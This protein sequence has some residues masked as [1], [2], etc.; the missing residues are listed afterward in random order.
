MNLSYDQN[1][2]HRSVGYARLC[3]GFEGSAEKRTSLLR[4]C[5]VSE[6]VL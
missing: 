1:G 2:T 6:R 5:E 4:L 3:E